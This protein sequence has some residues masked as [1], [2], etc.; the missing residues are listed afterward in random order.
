M[1]VE[2]GFTFEPPDIVFGFVMYLLFNIFKEFG[3]ARNHFEVRAGENALLFLRRGF[4]H[5]LLY[6]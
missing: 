5:C 1:G 3:I 6:N 2:V 4:L